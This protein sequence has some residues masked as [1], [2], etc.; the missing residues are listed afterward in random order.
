[1]CDV[2]EFDVTVPSIAR[3]YDYLLGGKDNFAVDRELGDKLIEAYPPVAET[4]RENKKFLSRAVSWVAGEGIGQFIDLGAGLPTSPS[5]QESAREIVPGAKV[6]YVDNDPVAISHLRALLAEGS[7]GVTVVDEDIQNAEAVLGAVGAGVDLSAPACLVMGS[8]VHFFPPDTGREVVRRYVAA[9]APGSF[10]VLSV[11]F[12]DDVAR[13]SGNPFISTYRQ[14]GNPLHNYKWAQV[15]ALFD[16]L[17]LV[18]PGITDVRAWRAG[19]TD[20]P[21]SAHPERG[22][23]GAVA[24]VP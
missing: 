13:A 11:G 1:M 12:D 15:E 9:L 8:L 7:P 10:L 23:V 17:E 14:G 16:G 24:R 5:T 18:G 4:A 2:P 21:R 6:A 22:I 20:L 19:W 3:V